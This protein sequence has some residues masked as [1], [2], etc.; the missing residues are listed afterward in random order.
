MPTCQAYKYANT[1]GI[2]TKDKSF[3]KIPEPKSETE[4]KKAQQLLRNM[5]MG[6]DTNT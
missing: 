5:A 1:T 4:R 2:T 3:F 6:Q